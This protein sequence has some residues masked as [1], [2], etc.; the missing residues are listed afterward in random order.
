MDFEDWWEGFQ[1]EN[2]DEDWFSDHGLELHDFVQENIETF[3]ELEGDALGDFW[4]DLAD[5]LDDHDIPYDDW[6]DIFNF[7]YENA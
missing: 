2:R 3:D 7:F 5:W 4:D 1:E 6:D